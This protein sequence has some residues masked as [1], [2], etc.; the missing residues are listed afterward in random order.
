MALE[1]NEAALENGTDEY[2]L[3]RDY[4]TVTPIRPAGEATDIDVPRGVLSEYAGPQ[5]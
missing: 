1:D 3:T 2:W 5:S 4:V